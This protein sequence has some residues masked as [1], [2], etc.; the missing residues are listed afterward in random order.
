[1]VCARLP[2]CSGLPDAWTPI[3]DRFIAYLATHCP[4][5]KDGK[6]RIYS[7]FSRPIFKLFYSMYRMLFLRAVRWDDT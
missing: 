4:L 6:V 1:M 7:I 5:T 2:S 3:H